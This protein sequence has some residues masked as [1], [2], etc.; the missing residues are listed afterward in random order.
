ML[1]NEKAKNLLFDNM[2]VIEKSQQ[3][4]E[5][6]YRA[7]LRQMPRSFITSQKKLF[8]M[9][10]KS[11]FDPIKMLEKLYSYMD[12][13]NRY[14]QGYTPCKKGCSNCC[15]IPISVTELDVYFIERSLGISR[16]IQKLLIL[17]EIPCPFL[18]SNACS[19][20]RYR[21][22]VCRK[23][24]TFDTSSR[25]C[26]AKVGANAP[27]PTLQLNSIEQIYYHLANLNGANT[28]FDIREI[29]VRQSDSPFF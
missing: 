6:N 29:F 27:M 9:I 28:L 17:P 2:N 20:Y 16:N 10:K 11:N 7:C 15:C 25:W 14:V 5:N 13:L 4:A 1:N 21:P 24:V 18:V 8:K 23:N 22:F 12:D 3:I 26:H 19:I